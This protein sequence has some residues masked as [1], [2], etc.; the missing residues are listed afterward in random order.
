MGEDG[1]EL[2]RERFS[3]QYMVDRIEEQYAECLRGS[4][5]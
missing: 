4:G 1:R 5:S 3:W 2:V